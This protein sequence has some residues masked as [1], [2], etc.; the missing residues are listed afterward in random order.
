MTEQDTLVAGSVSTDTLA[1]TVYVVTARKDEDPHS[2]VEAVYEDK[3]AAEQHRR[4]LAESARPPYAIAWGVHERE[5]ES[6]Y[7]GGGR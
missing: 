5:I 4:A 1:G 3:E 6:S 7:D 2:H